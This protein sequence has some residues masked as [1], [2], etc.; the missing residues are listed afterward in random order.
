[1]EINPAFYAF[2]VKRLIGKELNEIVVDPL[3]TFSVINYCE[4]IYFLFEDKYRFTKTRSAAYI[5]SYLLKEIKRKVEEFQGLILDGVV[6]TVPSSFTE[7]QK[8]EMIHASGNAGCGVPYLLPEPI[9]ALIAYS[10]ETNI[11]NGSITLLFDLGG[12]TTDICISKIVEN[13]IKVLIEMGDQFLGGKD[14]DKLLINH[15]NSILKKRYE[16]DVFATNKKFRLMI[17][18]QEIKHTL[19]VNMDAK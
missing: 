7:K 16:L 11:P 6:V 2:D 14:F 4:Q 8:Q 15:F 5:S 10:Y 19:S 9:A 1:M 3:W 18:C 12:G 13:E 17:K